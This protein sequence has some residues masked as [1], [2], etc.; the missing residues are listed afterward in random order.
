MITLALAA[1]SAVVLAWPM[2]EAARASRPG[3]FRLPLGRPAAA[4][5][6]A[7][8]ADAIHAL[9]IVRGRLVATESLAEKERAAVDSL[10]LALVN[11][12][13]RE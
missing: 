7:R 12:S 11:G 13:D 9:S 8:Y 4:P 6:H 5:R 1:A 2:L 3:A 10:T